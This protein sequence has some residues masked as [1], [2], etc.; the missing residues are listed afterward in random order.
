M[1]SDY[2]GID[3]LANLVFMPADK[4][5]S[6]E[7]QA[8]AS[9]VALAKDRPVARCPAMKR[10][11][12]S[13][14]ASIAA[15]RSPHPHRADMD[16]SLVISRLKNPHLITYYSLYIACHVPWVSASM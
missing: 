11:L 3:S 13:S 1:K 7:L 5:G 6:E 4:A 14:S 2:V 16:E 15:L 8:P 9:E 10:R 12:A